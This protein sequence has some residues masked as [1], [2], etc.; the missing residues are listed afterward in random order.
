MLSYEHDFAIYKG[1]RLVSEENLKL[2]ACSLLVYK[3]IKKGFEQG[4]ENWNDIEEIYITSQDRA[5]KNSLH[6]NGQACDL[7]VL[8]VYYMPYFWVL[9]HQYTT[10]NV[11]LSTHNKHIHIDISPLYGKELNRKRLEIALVKGDD[12]ASS[13]Y[14]F[15]KPFE[16]FILSAPK[17]YIDKNG[18]R[19]DISEY[20]K[21]IADLYDFHNEYTSNM[22][23]RQVSGNKGQVVNYM[24]FMGRFTEE[25][26]PDNKNILPDFDIMRTI[27]KVED[28]ISQGAS[29]MFTIAKVG[30]IAALVIAAYQLT[31]SSK[32]EVYYEQRGEDE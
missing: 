15:I 3:F 17:E 28:A 7:V 32:Q 10:L 16:A 21:A 14:K 30:I 2:N 20:N 24:T 23:S 31:K 25:I 27:D 29:S 6:S 13:E 26:G 1:G 8:P 19:Y 18:N 5:T 4:F 22:F 9:L 12:L 11:C